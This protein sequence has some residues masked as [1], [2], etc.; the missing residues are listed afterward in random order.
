MSLS[1]QD[2]SIPGQDGLILKG[3]LRDP[4]GARRACTPVAIPAHDYAGKPDSFLP[5]VR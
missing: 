4:A 5:L 3:T 1:L 2:Q